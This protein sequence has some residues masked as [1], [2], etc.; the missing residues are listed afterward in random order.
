MLSYFFSAVA[1]EDTTYAT[2]QTVE[3]NGLCIG[4]AAVNADNAINEDLNDYST[5]S[6]GLSALGANISQ[7][8]IFPSDQNLPFRRITINLAR[9]D[10]LSL[11]L[12]GAVAVRTSN[13]GVD[14]D[15]RHLIADNALVTDPASNRVTY[16]FQSS[17]VFDRVII[18]L[19]GGIL[20]IGSGIRIYYAYTIDM[21]H[22]TACGKAPNNPLAYYPLD[23]NTRDYGPGRFDGTGLGMTYT[24]N[25]ICSKAAFN[26]TE[27]DQRFQ[28]NNF[29]GVEDYVTVAF[30]V[31][32]TSDAANDPFGRPRAQFTLCNMEKIN[33]CEITIRDNSVAFW[34]RNATVPINGFL[35]SQNGEWVTEL[36]PAFNNGYCHVVAVLNDR[37]NPQDPHEQASIVRIYINGVAANAVY[38]E[39]GRNTSFT[40]QFK[41]SN[42]YVDD[43]LIYDRIFRDTEIADL[44]S[45]Y[46][47]KN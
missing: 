18:E 25:A 34:V 39:T 27:L 16:T 40:T 28:V 44:F 3:T 29:P 46:A 5:L 9:T 6:V 15:D 8:L 4:C 19:N 24:N 11:H 37:P 33:R 36:K 38:S 20:A 45:S 7:S 10:G 42:C 43:I 1:Q 12:L 47:E 26:D 41:I 31:K 23:G 14:N 21:D 17:K 32:L 30:W 2:S 35:R 22:I 13:N